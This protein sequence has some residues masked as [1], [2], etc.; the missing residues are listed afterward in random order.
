[1]VHVFLVFTHYAMSQPPANVSILD[2][3]AAKQPAHSDL[4]KLTVPQD[5]ISPIPAVR[6][7][8]TGRTFHEPAHFSLL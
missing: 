1:M 2:Y 3:Y 6:D 5:E 7:K 8:F 4:Y